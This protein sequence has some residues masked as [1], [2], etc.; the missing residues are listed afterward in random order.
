MARFP[1]W[2]VFWRGLPIDRIEPA[3]RYALAEPTDLR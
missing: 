3:I 1:E 2:F